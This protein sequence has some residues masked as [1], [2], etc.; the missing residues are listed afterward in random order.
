MQRSLREN[1]QGTIA[2][3]R[4]V[5]GTPAFAARLGFHLLRAWPLSLAFGLPQLLRAENRV[6]YRYQYYKEDH[7]RMVIDTHS[8]YFEQ[9]LIDA[10]IAKGE[11]IYDGISGATPTGTVLPSGKVALTQLEDIRRAASMEFDCK[12]GQHTLTPGLAYS[13]ESDYESIGISLSDG[14]EF[15]NKNT[16]L[17][18]GLAHN[19]DSVRKTDR[20]NWADKDSTEGYVGISQLLSPKTIFT[21]AF[22]LGYDSGYLTDPYRLAGYIPDGFP[23]TIG[24]PERRPGYRNKQI[25]YTSLTQHI[26]PADASIEGSYRFYHDSYGIFSHTV[27]LSWH[28]WLGKHLMVES[29]FRVN[30]QSAADFY[31]ITFSGPFSDDPAGLHSSDY[32]L[33]ELYT[34]DYG[35]QGTGIINE[36]LRL[37]A[38]YHRYEMN[39][40][41][42]KTSQGMYPAAHI[43]TIGLAIL[44]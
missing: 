22:T 19:F 40:L 33:S 11:L 29:F 23:F 14:I 9:K 4:A 21:A 15:N 6:E 16:T 30:Q 2:E 12:L 28:Q 25:V 10:I 41:D 26:T 31:S 39:G 7:D 24:V 20:I 8:V 5:R 43:L 18:F 3:N 44:W 1:D 38:G 34:L 13:K 27:A 37:T 35:L 36:H 32:R 17:Q 42:G